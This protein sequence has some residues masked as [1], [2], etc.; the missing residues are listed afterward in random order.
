MTIFFNRKNNKWLKYKRN[1]NILLS[2]QSIKIIIQFWNAKQ[3]A[4]LKPS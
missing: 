1:I 3:T 4:S 2:K